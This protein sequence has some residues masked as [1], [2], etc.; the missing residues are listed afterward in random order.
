MV[1]AYPAAATNAAE[2]VTN[3]PCRDASAAVSLRVPRSA[4]KAA[5][6]SGR[7]TSTLSVGPG[8]SAIAVFHG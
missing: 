3:D 2:P 8:A 6:H 1:A 7:G 5:N 4:R